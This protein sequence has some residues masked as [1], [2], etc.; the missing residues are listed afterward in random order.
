M[1]SQI[2]NNNQIVLINDN[3]LEYVQFASFKKHESAIK[4][5]FTSRKGGV[6]SG[7]CNSLNLGFNRNDTI[8]NILEN[9]KRISA[10]L[11]I[12]YKN[13]VFSNQ[14]HDNKIRLVDESD[15]GKG[16]IR[17]S[18]IIGFDGLI[19]DKKDVALVTFYADCVPV[20]F[21][22]PVKKVIG[23]AHS[24]WR[25]TVKEIAG[26]MVRKFNDIYRCNIE[27]IETAIGPSIGSCCFEVGDEVYTEFVDKLGWSNEFCSKM[28]NN[29]WHISLQS[30]IR[31]TLLD[32]GIHGNKICVSEICTKCNKNLFFSHRGDNGKT[33]SLAAIMQLI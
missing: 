32:S 6:S 13:M 21:F 3:G 9:Y 23:I 15:R 25:G 14:V 29:R 19:T 2:E 28:D 5:C 7:E 18:D 33:G 4:H 1:K 22:D 20:F 16:I 11:G 27:D 26:A 24:G 31:K 10:S 17:Q 8:Q 12:D 30:V